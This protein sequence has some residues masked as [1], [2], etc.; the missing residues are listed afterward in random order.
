[1]T[2]ISRCFAAATIPGAPH[3][4]PMERVE[5]SQGQKFKSL[6]LATSLDARV[7]AGTAHAS[8]SKRWMPVVASVTANPSYSPRNTTVNWKR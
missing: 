1:M 4:A 5:P 3:G 6:A 7:L 2:R 8:T